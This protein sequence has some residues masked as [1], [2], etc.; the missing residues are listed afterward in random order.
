[1]NDAQYI[2]ERV[3]DQIYWYGRKSQKNKKAYR[4]LRVLGVAFALSVPIMSGFLDGTN[5]SWLKFAISL[6]GAFVALCEALLTLYKFRD[7]WT[8]YRN[9]GEMLTQHKYLFSTGAAPYNGPDAF[10]LLVQNAEAVMSGER[11]SWVKLNTMPEDKLM[12]ASMQKDVQDADA[13]EAQEKSAAESKAPEESASA[14]PAPGEESAETG[15]PEASEG[16]E[17]DEP[18]EDK[19]STP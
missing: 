6:A 11:I 8:N 17:G 5:A 9:A 7:N 12:P 15:A 3:Q 13:G 19:P 4:T 1:M 18:S 10:I 16:Q 14:A 2:R